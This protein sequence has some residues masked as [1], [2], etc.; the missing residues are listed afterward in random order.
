M[1]IKMCEDCRAAPKEGRS[2][3]CR[4]CRKARRTRKETAAQRE[5]RARKRQAWLDAQGSPMGP[6]PQA[7]LDLELDRVR[8]VVNRIQMDIHMLETSRRT[9]VTIRQARQ[10][11]AQLAAALTPSDS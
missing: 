9:G 1:P 11:A 4:D 5:R 7:R 10:W 3:R 2:Y 6:A 8:A